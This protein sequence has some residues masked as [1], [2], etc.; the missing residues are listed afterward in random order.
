MKKTKIIQTE[1]LRGSQHYKFIVWDE[2]TQSNIK[3]DGVGEWD[4]WDWFSKSAREYLDLHNNSSDYGLYEEASKGSPGRVCKHLVEVMNCPPYFVEQAGKIK[5]INEKG[6][7]SRA[8][9]LIFGKYVGPLF[10]YIVLG[11]FV[12]L[13][14]NAFWDIGKGML[15][16]VGLIDY[17][18]KG[19]IR[20]EKFLVSVSACNLKDAVHSS[21]KTDKWPVYAV[22]KCPDGSRKVWKRKV[23]VITEAGKKLIVE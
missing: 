7:V 17:K 6:P 11:L 13:V 18:T 20:Y 12:W 16:S 15:G 21:E 2:Q 5:K 1:G 4:D 22:Y 23:K 8:I 19:E 10:A 14:G 9:S 3:I